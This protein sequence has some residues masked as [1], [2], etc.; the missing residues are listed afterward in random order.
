MTHQL[1]LAPA[2]LHSATSIAAAQ[3]IEPAAGTLEWE[4][5]DY[6]RLVGVHGAT[7]DEIQEALSMQGSTQRPRRIKLFGKG[8]VTRGERTRK[9]K[10]GRDAVVWEAVQ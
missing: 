10:S 4:V 5:L 9:T 1:E 7:D 3:A 2:Q 8:L 6:L